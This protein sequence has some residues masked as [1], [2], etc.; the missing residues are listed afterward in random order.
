LSRAF[1]VQGL[2][3][4]TAL[5][6]TAVAADAPAKVAN[7]VP[8]NRV[9]MITD[10][11]GGVLFWVAE[12]RKRLARGLDLDLETKTCRK[13]IAPGCPAYDDPAPPSALRTI[14]EL[15][16]QLGPTVV[17]D[18][19][20]ND[21]AD[22]YASSLDQ[23]MRALLD[24][25][26]QHVVWVTL[27]ETQDVWA[28]INAEIGTARKRWPQLGVADWALFSAGKPWFVDGVH[29]NSEG[30]LAF[31]EFLRPSILDACG[32]PCAPP[33]PLGIDTARLPMAREGK[34]YASRVSARGGVP[35]YRWSVT[36][37]PRGLHLSA[38]GGVTGTPRAAGVWLISLRVQDA[39]DEDVAG[40]LAVRVR[41]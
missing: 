33:P 23:V 22:D 4:L 31:A 12:A 41:R 8:P 30:G 14:Q 9:T 16:P 21:R 15:G 7:A 18:V 38:A 27:V 1:R 29:M 40:V 34:P 11:V 13:L 20:Y 19:G 32:Q 25:G 10:S 3:A 24:A 6:L 28:H 39:W 26:V 36:G 2:A 35:P 37:L 5:A 17:I